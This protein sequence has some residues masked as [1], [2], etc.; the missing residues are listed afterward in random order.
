MLPLISKIKRRKF[1]ISKFLE[2]FSI[3]MTWRFEKYED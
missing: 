1:N 3:K 2:M